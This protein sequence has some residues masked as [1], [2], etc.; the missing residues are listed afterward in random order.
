M[1]GFT[2]VPLTRHGRERDPFTTEIRI[3]HAGTPELQLEI[4]WVISPIVEKLGKRAVDLLVSWM[5]QL[6]NFEPTPAAPLAITLALQHGRLL[7]REEAEDCLG[8]ATSM[9]VV[10]IT[11]AETDAVASDRLVIALGNAAVVLK[12]L[13]LQEESH[14]GLFPFVRWLIHWLPHLS[15][16]KNG[17]IRR[18]AALLARTLA[19]RNFAESNT[20]EVLQRLRSDNRAEVRR[21]AE[22]ERT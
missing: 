18:N 4:G 12:D 13:P 7:S 10:L 11:A 1:L 20:A 17:G 22:V 6:P 16:M 8:I 5:R 19:E 15:Q 9:L 21:A 14:R 2:V 3:T